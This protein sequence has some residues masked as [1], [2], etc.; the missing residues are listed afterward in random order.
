MIYYLEQCN[1][2]LKI[3]EKKKVEKIENFFKAHVKIIKYRK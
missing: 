2:K 3:V 1:K